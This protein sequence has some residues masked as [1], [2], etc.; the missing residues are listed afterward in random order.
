MGR[1]TWAT[2]VLELGG[3]TPFSFTIFLRIAIMV[4][5]LERAASYTVSAGG[6]PVK[7]EG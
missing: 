1:H 3:V 5:D 2:E 4:S 7:W 6:K